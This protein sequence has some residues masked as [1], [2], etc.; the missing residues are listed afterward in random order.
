MKEE[1]KNFVNNHKELIKYVNEDKMTW[2]KFYD[3]YVLYGKD[4]DVWDEYLKKDNKKSSISDI[5]DSIKKIDPEDLQK[6]INTIKK[7]LGLFSS[8][9]SKEDTNP[10]Y[11]PMPLYKK[12]ED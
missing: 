12:F 4:N 1:F 7:A 8:L 9:L 6:N 10:K 11:E 2:Q 5:I 3:M